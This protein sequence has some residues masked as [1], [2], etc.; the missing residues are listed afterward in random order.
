MGRVGGGLGLR[1]AAGGWGD[2][3]VAAYILPRLL[4]DCIFWLSLGLKRGS[5]SA[6]DGDKGLD[7]K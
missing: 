3:S 1:R 5:S 7:A 2:G 6:F 4:Y